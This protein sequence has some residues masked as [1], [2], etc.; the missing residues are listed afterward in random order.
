[1]KWLSAAQRRNSCASLRP[2]ADTGIRRLAR[3][4]AISSIL[5][6]IASQSLTAA[7]TSPSTLWIACSIAGIS[8]CVWITT[9]RCISDSLPAPS[10][11]SAPSATGLPALSRFTGTTGCPSTCT[12]MP[13]SAS[14][15]VTESTRNGMSSLATW[16]TVCGDSQPSRSRPGLK[17]RTE[18]VPGLRAR[19]SSKKSS[20]SAA[21]PWAL[22]CSSSSAVMRR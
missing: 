11:A 9:S 10:P 8:A 6:R 14:A 4:S 15:M 22:C 20:A 2:A 5:L 12:P 1:M 17:M 21:Q 18:A 19:T 3:S 7:R 16:I 13:C